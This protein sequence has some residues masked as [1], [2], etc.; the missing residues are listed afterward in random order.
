MGRSIILIIDYVA[1]L[2]VGRQRRSP[3]IEIVADSDLDEP[4]PSGLRRT[5]QGGRTGNGRQQ[6]KM[7]STTP[8]Y[9]HQLT[10]S[11][12]LR[13]GRE[14]GNDRLAEKYNELRRLLLNRLDL[15]ALTPQV[16]NDIYRD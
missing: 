3:S 4:R 14:Q 7:T 9:Q 1:A 6:E 12:P 2:P 15:R 8:S 11:Q 16:L 5:W 13:C 10:I